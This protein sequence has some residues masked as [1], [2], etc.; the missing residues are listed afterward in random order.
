MRRIV[1]LAELGRLW[2]TGD[3]V[4]PLEDDVEEFEQEYGPIPCDGSVCCPCGTC[5]GL[6]HS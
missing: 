1:D 4:D 5:D 3:L 6:E 2:M